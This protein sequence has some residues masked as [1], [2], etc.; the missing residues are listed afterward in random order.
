MA[1][2]FLTQTKHRSAQPERETQWLIID[3]KSRS[4]SASFRWI[5]RLPISN[6]M[7]DGFR[8]L[9]WF[10]GYIH[11]LRCQTSKRNFFSHKSA[12]QCLCTYKEILTNCPF[13]LPN[14]NIVLQSINCI[15]LLVFFLDPSKTTSKS[16]E[17]S[18]YCDRFE[19]RRANRERE[20]IPT[21]SQRFYAF[22]SIEIFAR[23][24]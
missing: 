7:F 11:L 12:K 14:T 4:W 15:L 16:C 19:R 3:V 10:T 6:E 21:V 8:I 24:G 20:K 9:L 23:C 13:S 5:H 2:K 22:A 17:W 1:L 18:F